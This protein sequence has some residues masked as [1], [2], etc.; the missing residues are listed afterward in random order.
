MRRLLVISGVLGL[1]CSEY[2]INEHQ[3][4]GVPGDDIEDIDPN[5]GTGV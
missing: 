1:A 3:D 5:D 2:E 4:P